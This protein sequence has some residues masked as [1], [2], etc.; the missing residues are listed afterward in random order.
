MEELL[1]FV[2]GALE[3]RGIDYMLSG[4]VALNAYSIPRY[5]RDIDIVIELQSD[6][7]PFFADI[8]T[9]RDCY[10]HREAAEVEVRRQ[11]MFNIIDW[12]SGMK[13]DFIVRK[14]DE[15]QQTEFS[16]RLRKT[17]LHTIECWII[18]PEDLILA[19][20]LW[21]QQ[22]YSQQ[23]VEDIK[24]V[25]LDYPALDKA[26]IIDW[27]KKLQLTTFGLFNG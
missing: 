3:E 15:F 20:L 22:L 24:N 16:R 17:I 11:G 14:N 12:H 1:K 4:S 18:S 9:G 5:T 7:F 21:T 26:Y 25:I 27:I 8:F 23:Q 6:N 19:K 13:V 2:C 10:F